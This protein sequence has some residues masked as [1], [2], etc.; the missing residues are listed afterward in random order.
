M[1]VILSP[2]VSH[3]L[4][5]ALICP[6]AYTNRQARWTSAI[7]EGGHGSPLLIYCADSGNYMMNTTLESAHS[8]LEVG[9]YIY[10]RL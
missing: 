4:L 6:P 8:Y 3:Y 1:S 2:D 9:L 5:Y 10:V 7:T